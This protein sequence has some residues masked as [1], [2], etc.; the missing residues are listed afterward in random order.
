MKLLS[1]ICSAYSS[2]I[3]SLQVVFRKEGSFQV[4][5]NRHGKIVVCHQPSTC[6]KAVLL[7][8][9]VFLLAAVDSVDSMQVAQS[10]IQVAQG[11]EHAF[12]IFGCYCCLV[13]FQNVTIRRSWSQDRSQTIPSV[14]RCGLRRWIRKRHC[15]RCLSDVSTTTPTFKSDRHVYS[16]I[17]SESFIGILS[18]CLGYFVPLSKFLYFVEIINSSTPATAVSKN[19]TI[20]A[21]VSV[22]HFTGFANVAAFD[23]TAKDNVSLHSFISWILLFV[24]KKMLIIQDTNTD[25][26]AVHNS[27]RKPFEGCRVQC[28]SGERCSNS[29]LHCSHEHHRV[30]RRIY[31]WGGGF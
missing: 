24:P 11:I 26:S 8:R 31:N 25:F 9:C 6:G 28:S 22:I 12:V 29:W 13:K 20:P 14:W 10:C 18:V 17:I 1:G 7:G 21:V 27:D 2:C 23:Q 30:S 3:A 5:C 4:A 16:D 15:T 19:A